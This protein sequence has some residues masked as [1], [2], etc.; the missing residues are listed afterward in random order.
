MILPS[1]MGRVNGF[2]YRLGV[3]G[4]GSTERILGKRRGNRWETKPMEESNKPPCAR[5]FGGCEL[6]AAAKHGKRIY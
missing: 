6:Q 2:R 4:G 1:Q 3:F 5:R